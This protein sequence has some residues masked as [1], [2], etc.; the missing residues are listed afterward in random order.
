MVK[1]AANEDMPATAISFKKETLELIREI[2]ES[3]GRSLASQVRIMCEDWL[4]S[5]TGAVALKKAKTPKPDLNA[6]DAG[7]LAQDAP[8]KTIEDQERVLT[9]LRELLAQFPDLKSTP[10]KKGGK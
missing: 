6:L 4:R 2:A 10:P 3:E 7:R 8:P 9:E 5:P 1:R